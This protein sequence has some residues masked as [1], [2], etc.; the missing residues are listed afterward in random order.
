M[1][2]YGSVDPISKKKNKINYTLISWVV[3]REV[4]TA[5]LSLVNLDGS[6]ANSIVYEWEKTKYVGK[7][8]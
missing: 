7:Y 1:T 5:S 3:M 8:T 2:L 6:I 4:R